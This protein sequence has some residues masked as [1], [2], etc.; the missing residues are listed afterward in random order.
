[1]QQ[2][3]ADKL[4]KNIGAK[5]KFYRKK[6]GLS[7][8]ELAEMVNIEMKSLSRIES[9]HNYPQCE[10]LVAIARALR[11]DPWRIY[12]CDSDCDIEKIKNTLY[13]AIEK[14]DNVATNLYSYLM[15]H[16]M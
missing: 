5:I 15:L 3:E 2:S 11:V 4:K 6:R 1:M 16:H 12:F 14:D 7:Q 13:S 10:N 8:N 9:G